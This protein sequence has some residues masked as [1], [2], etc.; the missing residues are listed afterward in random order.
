LFGGHCEPW[1]HVFLYVR[2]S[3]QNYFSLGKLILETLHENSMKSF[4][5]A[6]KE[7]N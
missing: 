5:I 1:V 3:P 4:F 6:Q 7:K 2:A